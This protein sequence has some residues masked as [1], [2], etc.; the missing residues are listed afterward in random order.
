MPLV[1][2]LLNIRSTSVHGSA[3][4]SSRS[5]HGLQVVALS[6]SCRKPPS[7]ATSPASARHTMTRTLASQPVR[8]G[9][10]SR[11]TARFANAA[12]ARSA[13]RARPPTHLMCGTRRA[14]IGALVATSTAGCANARAVRRARAITRSVHARPLTRTTSRWRHVSHGVEAIR[15]RVPSASVRVALRPGRAQIVH[16]KGPKRYGRGAMRELL[17]GE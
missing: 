3:I 8:S 15:S 17:H 6:R 12:A 14:R 1:L 16:S 2:F 7:P 10:P 9:A 4:K 11:Q 13:P 5:R